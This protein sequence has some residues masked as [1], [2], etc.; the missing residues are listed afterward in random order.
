[1]KYTENS[2]LKHYSICCRLVSEQQLT[3]L[4]LGGSKGYSEQIFKLHKFVVD[5]FRKS[6]I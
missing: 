2:C 1:M 6:G 4:T 3:G 5:H